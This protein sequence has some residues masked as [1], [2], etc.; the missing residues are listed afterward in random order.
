M[1]FRIK[2]CHI[3]GDEEIHL[4]GYNAFRSVKSQPTFQRNIWSP[5]SRSK[6]HRARNQNSTCH[7]LSRWFF[8][9]FI[10]RSSRW[11]R[12]VLPKCPLTF[13]GLHGVISQK[14]EFFGYSV[15][16]QLVLQ[17]PDIFFSDVR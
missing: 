17:L 13:N 7:L 15:S 6:I 1:V 16:I 9:W 8:A 5:S 4:L 14:I 11:R 3:A 10:L 12:H 2:G